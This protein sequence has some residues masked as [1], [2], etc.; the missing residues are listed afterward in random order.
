MYIRF[1]NPCVQESNQRFPHKK[2]T[3]VSL[4]HETNVTLRHAILLHLSM[5]DV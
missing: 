1:S 2:C 3:F 4:V 5:F